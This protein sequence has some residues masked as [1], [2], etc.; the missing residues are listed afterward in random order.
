MGVQISGGKQQGRNE[1]CACDSGLKF[2]YCHGDPV[3]QMLCTRVANEHMVSLIRQEQKKRGLIPYD[4]KCRHCKSGFDKPNQGV[5]TPHLP[6]C[7]KCGA[8]DIEENKNKNKGV[9]DEKG[10]K[11]KKSKESGI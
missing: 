8:T 5:V 1:R 2:K 6:M 10:E 11:S 7:P 9:G 4:W 3:K